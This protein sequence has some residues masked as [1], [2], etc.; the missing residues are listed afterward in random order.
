MNAHSRLAQLRPPWFSDPIMLTIS[1]LLVVFSLVIIYSATGTVSQER[2]GDTLFY[3]KRQAAAA[4]F[5]ASFLVL[6]ARVS[7]DRFR[8]VAP[9]MIWLCLGLVALTFVP[10]LGDRAGGAQRWL[11]L[12]V[13]RFQPAELVKL[14]FIIFMANYF[15]RHEN[16]IT[17]FKSGIFVPMLYVAVVAGLLLLQPD[18]GSAAIVALV[19]LGMALAAG[20]RPVYF[21]YS[22]VG[23]IACALPLI[24]FSPYRMARVTAFLNPF[25]DPAGKGYQLV[26]SLIAIGSG[27]LSGVG[28]GGSQQ[29]LFFLPAAHTDFIFSV[30]AEELG[31]VGGVCLIFIFIILLWRGL[32]LANRVAND[33]FAYTLGV[34][35]T[36]LIVAPALLNVGVVTGLLPTKGLVLPLVGYG[37][38]SLVSS[39]VAIGLLLSVGR[40][41]YFQ[42]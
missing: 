6:L 20:A 4:L 36:L 7:L 34:G 16:D 35:L 21:V 37:G 19:V 38:T 10:G 18:F 42:K 33:T 3:V 1:I 14:M 31:F 12:G 17:S 30:I 32:N 41:V 23:V 11:N 15:G 13:L 5:G 2:F 25:E 8:Q 40:S 9:Y 28:L 24:I 27:Q 29:K 26:Q 22:V 39:L